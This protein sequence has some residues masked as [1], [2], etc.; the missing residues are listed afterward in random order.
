MISSGYLRRLGNSPDTSA[1]LF[2]DLML[3]SFQACFEFFDA[4]NGI[5]QPSGKIIV[6]NNLHI[7]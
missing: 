1:V 4:G 2:L 7:F 6:G 5:S 3:Y